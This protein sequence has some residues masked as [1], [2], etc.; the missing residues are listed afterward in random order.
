[1]D[2]TTANVPSHEK[3]YPYTKPAGPPFVNPDAKTLRRNINIKF[4]TIPLSI[5]QETYHKSD[6]QVQVKIQVNPTMDSNPKR[7][8]KP[9]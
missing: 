1:M 8:Y 2:A 6:S 7:R 5:S 4:L 3:I 9:Q